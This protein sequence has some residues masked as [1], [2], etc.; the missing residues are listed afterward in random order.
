MKITKRQL[1]KIIK[2]EIEA[3]TETRGESG[4]N[5]ENMGQLIDDIGSLG[6]HLNPS[7]ANIMDGITAALNSGRYELI[8]Q[9]RLSEL[10]KL[11]NVDIQDVIE[12]LD[13]SPD[14]IGSLNAI[15]DNFLQLLN[16]EE[17]LDEIRRH[18]DEPK[19]P[20][21]PE[22]GHPKLRDLSGQ[23]PDAPGLSRS[24][25]ERKRQKQKQKNNT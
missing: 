24:G 13:G 3:I 17:D 9:E 23:G 4:Y 20:P 19:Y 6:D 15:R 14:E 18:P 25:L 2:E 1:Q 21:P 22:D 7:E 16:L 5:W 11:V 8:T 10:I 12:N